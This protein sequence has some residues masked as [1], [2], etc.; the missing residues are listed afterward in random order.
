VH[1]VGSISVSPSTGSVNG[2]YTFTGLG[3]APYD[4]VITYFIS[5]NHDRY[6]YV[7][8]DDDTNAV[9]ADESGS[10]EFTLSAVDDLAGTPGVWLAHFDGTD[11]LDVV[12][13]FRMTP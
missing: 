9:D 12:I 11:G 4:S 2:S 13:S 8:P 6:D 5:P 7:N 10:F 1:A 3:W